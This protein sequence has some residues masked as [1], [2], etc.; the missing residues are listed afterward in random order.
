MA[1]RLAQAGFQ[2]QAWNRTADK[3]A[4]LSADGVAISNSPKAAARDADALVVMVS[5]GEVCDRVLFDADIGAV[6]ALRSGAVVIVMSSI[7][8]D[9]A[10]RE[11]AMLGKQGVDYVDAPVSGGERGAVAGELTIMAG[12]D[13]TVVQ[14]LT[15][16]FAALGKLT[17]V[18]P[19]GC[20]QLAKLA[21]Q[22]IVGVTIGAVSEALLLAEAG[23]ARP[24][25]VREAL[26][27]GFAESAILRQHGARMIERAFIPGAHATTQLKDLQT[28]AAQAGS[29]GL[30][31]PFAA[32]AG[33]LFARMCEG[34][35]RS[36][37]HS[38]LY[39]EMRQ[40]HGR[41]FS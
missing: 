26:L 4:P 32:L 6:S 22:L 37:D 15:P 3:L 39:L 11:A 17:H 5:S 2:V 23:G 27:G 1:L 14:R 18:G 28:I 21:N 13:D 40:A 16:M 33:D 36:F 29:L 34:P 9:V 24:E 41:I 7:P 30:E 25:A 8:V 20:G 35:R 38:A 12:G 19:V 10:K 31:L